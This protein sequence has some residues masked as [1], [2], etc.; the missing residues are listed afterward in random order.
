MDK[1]FSL[2]LLFEAVDRVSAPARKIGLALGEVVRRAKLDRLMSELKRARARM[3]AFIDTGKK[4][5]DIGGSMLAKITAPISALGGASLVA[6][7]KMEQ[8]QVAFES[9]LGDADRAKQLVKD[10]SN[11]A[12][13][14]P[15]QLEGIGASAKQLLAFG[16]AQED[17]VDRLRLLG[18]IAAGANVP[19]EDMTAIFGKAKAKGKAMTE[20]LLQMSDRGI[21]IIDT[22]SRGLGKTGE[23][24][25]ELASQG[26]ISFE[27]LQKALSSMTSKGGI[28]FDQMQKQ[29]QT[30]AGRWSTLLDTIF[31]AGATFGQLLDEMFGVKELLTAVTA[32]I[33]KLTAN[34]AEFTAEHPGLAKI[35]L[36][37]AGIAAAAGPLLLTIGALLPVWGAMAAGAGVLAT[38]FGMLAAPIGSLIV[39]LR[40]GYSAMAALNLVMAANPIGAVLIAIA[41]LAAAAWLIV[42]NWESI[43]TFFKGLWT[44]ITAAFDEGLIQGLLKLFELFNPVAWVAKG[45]DALV[46]YLTG[47]SLKDLAYEWGSGFLTGFREAWQSVSA[48]V[49]SAFQKLTDWMP[50]WMKDRIGLGGT[51]EGGVPAGPAAAAVPSALAPAQPDRQQVDGEVRV[52]FD[53]LPAGARVETVRGQN[54]AV[55]L[56]VRA[57]YSMGSAG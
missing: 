27:I 9:M 49:A 1:K 3:Q 2:K 55:P 11:F 36:T 21:P 24:I 10:L 33:E 6:F 39:A 57:G 26:K 38:A 53:N 13:T 48:W 40:A 32:R 8:L 56:N 37:I 12:A 31:N 19:L 44:D 29:S 4:L 51:A 25:F 42:E 46:E 43:S 54:S 15:F 16:V 20:E 30:L 47:T 22:L 35:V 52:R 7:G 50:D 23:E 14:T 28:F 18:D 45:V 17:V 5:R 34:V 41:A